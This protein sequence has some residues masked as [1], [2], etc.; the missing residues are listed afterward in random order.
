MGDIYGVIQVVLG[1]LTPIVS[2]EI[3]LL[4]VLKD[5]VNAIKNELQRIA[6]FL[7]NAEERR[8]EGYDDAKEWVSQVRLL[9]Y[10]I[11]DAIERYQLYLKESA[12]SKTKQFLTGYVGVF[13]T[14][15]IKCKDTIFLLWD[16]PTTQLCIIIQ[17]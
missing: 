11:E 17:S 1:T 13:G 3:S 16:S 6:V 10:D 12:Y 8:T 5:D 15:N 9:A 14:N 2:G 4:S 7:K